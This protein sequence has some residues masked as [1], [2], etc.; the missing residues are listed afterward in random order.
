MELALR[1][2]SRNGGDTVELGIADMSIR[3]QHCILEN[4]NN[5]VQLFV[6]S[7]GES[8]SS[9]FPADQA[10][11]DIL[12]PSISEQTWSRCRAYKLLPNGLWRRTVVLFYIGIYNLREPPHTYY[13]FTTSFPGLARSMD[14]SALPVSRSNAN[15]QDVSTAKK[16][17]YRQLRAITMLSFL[18]GFPLLVPYWDN[19]K[20]VLPSIGI[21]PLFF[22]VV[23]GALITTGRLQ[24]AGKKVVIDTLLSMLYIAI[25]IPR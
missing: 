22:S 9:S 2:R 25:L 11:Q 15:M 14:A 13:I 1:S 21:F 8:A 20:R 10:S 17:E 12:A 7:E 16:G 3:S 4:A 19:T 24:L 23:S 18:F 5:H 6:L